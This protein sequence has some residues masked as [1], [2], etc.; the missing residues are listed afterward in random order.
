MVHRPDRILELL[1][2]KQLNEEYKRILITSNCNNRLYWLRKALKQTAEVYKDKADFVILHIPE[3]Y[4]LTHK[5]T[6]DIRNN[7][8][9]LSNKLGATSILNFHINQ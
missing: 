7:L 5:D 3:N 8:S 1:C 4:P 9:N 6:H 2:S